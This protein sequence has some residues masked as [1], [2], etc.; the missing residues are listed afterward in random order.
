VVVSF[1]L[2]EIKG[3]RMMEAFRPDVIHISSPGFLLF[4]ALFYAR[5]M[6]VPLLM[7]Y[8]TH[9]P[10]YAKQYLGY[11]PGIEEFAWM[12]LRFAHKR[13]DLTLATSPQLKKELEDNGIPRVD[14]WRKGIDTV[15]FDPKFASREAREMMSDGNPDDFLMVYVGRLGAE[16]RVA[17]CK[18]RMEKSERIQEEDEN[19]DNDEDVDDAKKGNDDINALHPCC[20]KA[21][22][23]SNPFDRR[24]A[25]SLHFA[26]LCFSKFSTR[27]APTPASPSWGAARRRRS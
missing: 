17:D 6:K 11:I 3:L 23:S 1:D 15:R 18:V 4:A 19:G 24:F 5:L 25:P 9:L 8:H 14:V 2:P 13:A 22:R 21:K 27:W 12:L 7:S 20:D 26:P 16:K 10:H